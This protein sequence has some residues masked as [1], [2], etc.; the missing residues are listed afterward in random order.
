[1]LKPE[2]NVF[3]Y[4]YNVCLYIMFRKCWMQCS[5]MSASF[6]SL[7]LCPIY[8][9]PCS[10]CPT[11]PYISLTLP[12]LSDPARSLS[13]CPISFTLHYLSHSILYLP[14]SPISPRC[15]VS[16][17]L[18]YFSHSA[19]YLALCPISATQPYFSHL[20]YLFHPNLSLSHYPTHTCPRGA[21]IRHIFSYGTL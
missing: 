2:W 8:L 6:L 11:L 14:P 20:P 15:P 5:L 7:P 12:C 4:T 17:T 21:D 3:L 10:I 9:P 19:L 18:P 1:M 13:S 16:P